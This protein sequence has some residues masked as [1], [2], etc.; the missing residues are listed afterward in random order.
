MY[1]MSCPSRFD[2]RYWML[3]AGALVR[4]RGRVWGGR[5]EE[6]S[7]R[8]SRVY[9]WWIHFDV[10]Q[11]TS[12][13][14]NMLSR[15][16]IAFLPRRKCLLMSRL[17]SPSAVILEPRKMKSVTVSI[18]FPSICHEGMGPDAM[19]FVFRMLSFKPTFSLSSRGS[20]VL[21]CFLP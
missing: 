1:E 13:L 20:L 21:L 9:L 12:L 14:L 4:P 6:G 16:V 8:G 15:W 7:G 3:L 2:A 10:W 5:M 11:N 17:Q 18:I 19:I